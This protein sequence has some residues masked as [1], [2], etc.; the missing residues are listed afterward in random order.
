[1][2]IMLKPFVKKIGSIEE[3]LKPS[4]ISLLD[5]SKHLCTLV[6]LFN[7]HPIHAQRA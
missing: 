6:C 2:P 7:N 1:M 3:T 4:F 5:M